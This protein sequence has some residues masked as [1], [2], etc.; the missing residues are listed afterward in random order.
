MGDKAKGEAAAPNAAGN[1]IENELM[2]S[3]AS[4]LG[5]TLPK[6]E[7]DRDPAAGGGAE[8]EHQG[9][10]SEQQDNPAG[11]GT[12]AGGEGSKAEGDA[13]AE[14]DQSGE[15]E[16]EADGE[17][18]ADDADKGKT[19]EDADEQGDKKPGSEYAADTA[20]LLNTR[21]KDL[22]PE[23][24]KVV[25]GIIGARIG[26]IVAKERT[27]RERLGQRVEE[28]A[29]E[30]QQL[31]ASKGP[32]IV[33]ATVH[34]TE[35]IESPDELTARTEKLDE[36]LDWADDHKDGI[37]PVGEPGEEGYKPGHTK[38]EIRDQARKWRK[39]KEQLIPRVR[40]T[41]RA[42]AQ[43]DAVLRQ[44]M[45]EMFDPK[46]NE[47]RFAQQ[48]LQQLP[49]LRRFADFRGILAQQILGTKLLNDRYEAFKKKAAPGNGG[50]PDEKAKPKPG[51]TLRK[52]A[53]RAPGSGTPAKGSVVARELDKPAAAQA[54]SKV[55]SDPTNRKAF[56]AAVESLLD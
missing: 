51:V 1:E 44:V 55:Y 38:D 50:Q 41:L 19:G 21:L 25:E 28:L 30:N 13:T 56:N 4:R 47:Y 37:E 7:S 8:G 33:D 29:A 11:D 20:K 17:H 15:P 3:V 35:L 16:G 32:R 2:D 42:R 53:P 10:D 18:A 27:E 14:D 48:M 52:P 6:A 40:E 9:D 26:Q 12:E 31:Q 36:W 39:E 23:Q 46:T 34:P 22:A 45:P 5:T 43:G 24:R 49:Q 54:V